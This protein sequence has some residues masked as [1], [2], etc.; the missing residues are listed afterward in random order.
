[1]P[2]EKHQ[3]ATPKSAPTPAVKAIARAPQKVTRAADVITDAP[4]ARAA[5]EPTDTYSPA[6]IDMAPANKAGH[7]CDEDTRRARPGCRD[8]QHEAGGGNDAVVGSE[9]GRAEP[10]NPLCPMSFDVSHHGPLS[11]GDDPG[12]L[13]IPENTASSGHGE[14]VLDDGRCRSRIADERHVHAVSVGDPVGEARRGPC[15]RPP[16]SPAARLH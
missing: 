15:Q 14:N 10:A 9:H 12:S 4:P 8:A 5:S 13:T 2:K 6:A 16:T 3:A 1:M 7:A 11:E